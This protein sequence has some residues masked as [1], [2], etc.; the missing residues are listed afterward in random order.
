MGHV[1]PW[2]RLPDRDRVTVLAPAAPVVAAP[3][4]V[5]AVR[6]V[7]AVV[8]LAAVRVVAEATVAAPE[9]GMAVAPEAGTRKP[10]HISVCHV[11]VHPS[12]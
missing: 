7:V 1:R 2:V 12:L 5:A 8:A 3:G 4:P 9:A 6:V 10:A 11:S